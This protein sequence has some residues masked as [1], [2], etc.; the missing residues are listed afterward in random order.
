MAP[1]AASSPAPG[2]GRRLTAGR[3]AR[4]RDEAVQTNGLITRAGLLPNSS[5]NARAIGHTLGDVA[6]GSGRP[7]LAGWARSRLGAVSY[8]LFSGC[9][10]TLDLICRRVIRQDNSSALRG[11]GRLPPLSAGGASA[12]ASGAPAKRPARGDGGTDRF[13]TLSTVDHIQLHLEYGD[14]RSMLIISFT[15]LIYTLIP[16]CS[17]DVVAML[18]VIVKNRK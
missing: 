11:C 12:V 10:S 6:E 1:A 9:Q 4:L 13:P 16:T 7:H 17:P 2:G 14:I 3:R 15:Y 18:F 5:I 8:Q